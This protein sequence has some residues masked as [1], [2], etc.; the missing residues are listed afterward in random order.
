[1]LIKD[2]TQVSTLW[3]NLRR[4]LENDL[5]PFETVANFFEQLP[6]VKIYTDPYDPDTWPTPW[7]LI[8]ENEYCQFN[9]LLG[10]CYTIQLTERFK[11]CHPKIN[12]AIDTIN[13]T[14]YYLLIIN[15]KVYGY[16]SNWIEASALPKSLKIQKMYAMKELH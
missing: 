11:N 14:V 13:K 3:Y 4:Q 9:I 8:D 7:E 6:K 1:M 10:I 12:V 5:T 15:D 2:R 16:D